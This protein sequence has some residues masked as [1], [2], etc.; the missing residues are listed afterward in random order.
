MTAS[1][2][3]ALFS[4]GI[5][6]AHEAGRTE[7]AKALRVPLSTVSS[8]GRANYIPEWRQPKLLELAQGRGITLS[9]ADFPTADQRVSLGRQEA[10]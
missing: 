1:D 8:W 5:G 10:A 4:T 7:L 2:I 3:I 9:T 6:P